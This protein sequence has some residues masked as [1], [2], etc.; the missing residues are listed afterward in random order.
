MEPL[1]I[2]VAGG[3]AGV[4]LTLV[5]RVPSDI[6]KHNRLVYQVDD[7]LA[8]WVSDEC[9]HLE[10]ELNRHKNK[11]GNQLYAGSYLHGIAHIK[12]RFLHRYRDQERQARAKVG[13]WQD[14]EGLLHRI[15]RWTWWAD[16]FPSLNTPEAAAPILEGGEKTYRRADIQPP[17]ATQLGDRWN[18]GRSKSTARM[19]GPGITI[20]Q[21]QITMNKRRN[22]AVVKQPDSEPASDRAESWTIGIVRFAFA[23]PRRYAA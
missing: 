2:A 20:Y 8:Q 13:E 16:S 12:E 3:V 7:D 15:V 17:S 21:V 11:A 5:V 6:R 10:R 1:L 23:A 22:Q 18:L 19:L 4:I 14:A 9:V